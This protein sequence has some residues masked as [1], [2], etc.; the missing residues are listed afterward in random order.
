MVVLGR[1][2][3]TLLAAAEMPR[4]LREAGVD[5]GSVPRLAEQATRQWTGGFNPRAVSVADFVDLY[6]AAFAGW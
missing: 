2:I 3:H 1:T 5:P 4:S 6:T